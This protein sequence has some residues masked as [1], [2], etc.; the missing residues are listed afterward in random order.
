MQRQIED[1]FCL[2]DSQLHRMI[3]KQKG[4]QGP[5]HSLFPA[6]KGMEGNRDTA[7]IEREETKETVTPDTIRGRHFPKVL[8]YGRKNVKGKSIEERERERD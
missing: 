2:T 6:L 3:C 4:K 5:S 8:F 7:L 1:D